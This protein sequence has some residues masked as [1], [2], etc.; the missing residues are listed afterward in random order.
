LSL[1]YTIPAERQAY[2]EVCDENGAWS[3]LTDIQSVR[4]PSEPTQNLANPACAAQGSVDDV[5]LASS[6]A[7]TSQPPLQLEGQQVVHYTQLGPSPLA[8]RISPRF[9]YEFDWTS[10]YNNHYQIPQQVLQTPD[11]NHSG[12]ENA[13]DGGAYDQP[14][15][16]FTFDEGTIS[17][18]MNDPF[19]RLGESPLEDQLFD[20]S[21]EEHLGATDRIAHEGQS[22]NQEL[23]KRPKGLAEALLH[24][25]R[26]TMRDN[27]THFQSR[28]LPDVEDVI[29]SLESLLP[30]GFCIGSDATDSQ[31][32]ER[33]ASFGPG[34]K[35]L[36]YSI[37]NGFAGLR[38]VPRSSIMKL[39]RDDQQTQSHLVKLLN[40]SSSSLAKPLADNLFRAA[41]ESC[42]P[43]AVAMIMS[44]TG[45]NA[46][47]AIDPNNIVCEFSD[48]DYTPIELAAK[49]RNNEIV[50]ALLTAN[51]DPNKTYSKS[52]MDERGALELAIRK[53]GELERVDPKLVNLLLDCGAKVRPSLVEAV[54]RWGNG[55]MDLLRL[56][57]DRIPDSQHSAIFSNRTI[58]VDAVD[59][60]ENEAATAI[61]QR[62]FEA[63]KSTN[64]GKCIPSQP[65]LL[66]GMLVKA[67]KR[68]NLKLVKFLTPHTNEKQ[69]ALAA[70]VRIGKLQLVNF[71][72]DNGATVD[73]RGGYLDSY[74]SKE[75]GSNFRSITTPLAEAIR[76][77]DQ[78]QIQ[79]F[80]KRGALACI[81]QEDHFSAAV[82]AAAETGHITYLEKVLELVPAY[83]HAHLTP[84]LIVAIQNNQTGVALVLLD[85]GAYVNHGGS[86][87][88]P[89]PPLVEALLRRNR[90]VVD[91]ILE[92]DL[93]PNFHLGFG[94]TET[95]YIE[96]AG[97]WGVLEIIQDLALIGANLNAGNKTTALTTAVENRNR[98]LV[99]D[100][101]D[102][103]A[104]ANSR[105]RS[106]AS[107]LQAAVK[108]G[109]HDM[110]LFLISQ[111]ASV[112]NEDAFLFAAKHDPSA[113]K[114]LSS[115][116]GELH[117]RDRQ[118]FG[119]KLLI[120]FITQNDMEAVAT[121]IKAKV[122][123]NSICKTLSRG[124]SFSPLGFAVS[125][126]K[127]T[128]HELVRM[129]LQAGGDPNGI[130]TKANIGVPPLHTPLLLAIRTRNEEMVQI[131]VNAGAHVNRPARRGIKHT[132]LQGACKI[133]SFKMVKFLLLNGANVNDP[134]AVR[135]GH[136]ALQLAAIN[137][138]LKIV[139]LLIDNHA[140]PHGAPA[141]V[142]G[143]TAFE[144]A[145]E[146]GCL[147]VL[148]ELSIAASPRHFSQKELQKAKG[149]AAG[150]GHR[151]CVDYI[152]SLPSAPSGGSEPLIGF[153]A[154]ERGE[155][156]AGG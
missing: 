20:F 134:A 147:D 33:N 145:A 96:L 151:S 107:P 15:P 51:A 30:E 44:I 48:R 98:P 52:E 102:L 127:G 116:L 86:I 39:I 106:G 77:Q 112:I 6:P 122:D 57:M 61:V 10:N 90:V 135:G 109:D 17:S 123:I 40:T 91:A 149:L 140:D 24:H 7:P 92:S 111:G 65:E 139:T 19:L 50:Q 75:Y 101:L 97:S 59:Y 41:V 117:L 110:M 133:N 155:T 148:R 142:R 81:A 124:Q 70:A 9:L 120:H 100:L 67:A 76:A 26:Q 49:F 128:R 18:L 94:G 14:F 114:I 143:Q 63:C 58:L 53:W 71:L 8:G 121:L 5:D 4:N 69:L 156:N 153:E 60:L 54:V 23:Q 29:D 108:N 43:Q 31:I 103:G 11:H 93:N 34:F 62:F 27:A 129:L 3:K 144:G 32:I 115:A 118:K 152:D 82:F 80:E 38:N 1:G 104:S 84:A 130:A 113:Y 42:D 56:L 95:Q 37:I 55:D 36:L 131:L 99:E 138:S 89:G 74:V 126:D 12:W 73:G 16:T 22:P 72:L 47:I 141:K 154:S 105:A 68:G 45:N 13:I 87:H 132:P 85:A 88:G 136:T 21:P 46:E 35:A 2:I 119:G 137:G 79:D 146:N 28:D 25:A 83:H 150:R 64:C 66:Q 78:S 125:Y